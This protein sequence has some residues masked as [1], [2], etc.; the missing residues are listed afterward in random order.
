ML[1]MSVLV[2]SCFDKNP[3][4]WSWLT[5]V[6]ANGGVTMIPYHTY[7]MNIEIVCGSPTDAC[8]GITWKTRTRVK[9]ARLVSLIVI[10]NYCH[11]W[12]LRDL[13]RIML[14]GGYLARSKLVWITMTLSEM[15]D[16][17][18]LLS[19]HSNPTFIM[20]IWLMRMMLTTLYSR[21]D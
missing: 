8:W 3:S 9:W 12:G 2:Y 16:S 4:T 1:G 18:L 6:L 19:F 17:F 20:L 13:A 10:M 21:H 5:T 15:S 11:S 7:K 14:S